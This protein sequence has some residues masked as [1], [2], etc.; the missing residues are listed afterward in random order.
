MTWEEWL[1]LAACVP[2]VAVE[3]LRWRERSRDRKE[4]EARMANMKA[5]S[6]AWWAARG[7]DPNA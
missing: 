1:T 5:E 4:F 2:L 7:K 6:D 3:V